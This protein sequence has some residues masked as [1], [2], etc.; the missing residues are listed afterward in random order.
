MSLKALKNEKA[1]LK[2]FFKTR[3]SFCS[4]LN[5]WNGELM[6]SWFRFLMSRTGYKTNC[7]GM[8]QQILQRFDQ[9][10]L[11]V[12]KIFDLV[13]EYCRFLIEIEAI[14]NQRKNFLSFFVQYRQKKPRP[15]A[16]LVWHNKFC[17]IS[18]HCAIEGAEE[19]MRIESQPSASAASALSS[20]PIFSK[21]QQPQ[22][23]A[24]RCFSHRRKGTRWRRRTAAPKTSFWM[25]QP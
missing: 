12:I 3:W 9:N 7:V 16:A 19:A 15:L 18:A 2:M 25:E 11:S 8:A 24:F 20:I 22:Y 14:Q 17:T 1:R 4:T 23:T 10:K 5:S 13:I 21:P 6:N